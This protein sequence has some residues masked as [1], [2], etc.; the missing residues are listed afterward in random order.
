[1]FGISNLQDLVGLVKEKGNELAAEG[2][3]IADRL[4]L[5]RLQEEDGGQVARGKGKGGGASPFSQE[6][7]AGVL[8]LCRLENIGS[9][10]LILPPSL[11]PSVPPSLRPSVPPSLPTRPPSLH[12]PTFIAPPP[13]PAP[14]K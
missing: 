11:R 3:H 13:W 5:D 7:G 4:S 1:M 8:C 14:E 6:V 12:D 9:E 2:K 10:T